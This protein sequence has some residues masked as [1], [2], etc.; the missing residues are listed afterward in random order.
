VTWDI[1][2]DIDVHKVLRW[3]QGL[4]RKSDLQQLASISS[5]LNVCKPKNDSQHTGR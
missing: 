2:S 1:A 5:K 3:F 4:A